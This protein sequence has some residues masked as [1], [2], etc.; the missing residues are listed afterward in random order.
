MT[1]IIEVK[2]ALEEQNDENAAAVREYCKNRQIFLVNI[3]GSPGAGKT[4]VLTRT[5]DALGDSYS[6]GVIEADVDSDVD[7]RAVLEHG[8]AAVQLHTGGSCHMDAS[9]TLAGLKALEKYAP[10]LVFLENIG[11]LVCPAE[12]DTGANLNV[13]ILSAPEGDDKP[14]KYPLMFSVSDCLLVNKMDTAA[15]FDFDIEKCRTRVR[16]LNEKMPVIPLSAV[17]AEG[18]DDWMDFLLERLK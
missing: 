2:A 3:M 13:M 15:V 8:A 12:F 6:V 4:S 14:L 5:L 10:R 1:D 18:I 11:N 17:T 7:T 16:E 9:M